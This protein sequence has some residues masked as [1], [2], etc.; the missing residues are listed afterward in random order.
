MLPIFIDRTACLL[1]VVASAGAHGRHFLPCHAAERTQRPP[2]PTSSPVDTTTSMADQWQS[3]D[4]ERPDSLPDEVEVTSR[5]VLRSWA[6]SK[7]IPL[8]HLTTLLKVMRRMTPEELY[9]LPL[10]VRTLLGGAGNLPPISSL[11]GG[12]YVHLGLVT[13][14]TDQLRA[15][16]MKMV[17]H[18]RLFNTH[19]LSGPSGPHQPRR[20]RR[21]SMRQ[22]IRWLM[23]SVAMLIGQVS[24]LRQQQAAR[25]NHGQEGMSS[26]PS[27]SARFNLSS[28]GTPEQLD[29][30]TSALGE[31]NYR[32][33]LVTYLCSLGGDTVE[34]FVD[35]VFG[36]LFSENITT[37]NLGRRH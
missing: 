8:Q 3:P 14:L 10:D 24:E 31:E 25:M 27:E 29:A 23:H 6:V 18:K 12:E 21:A 1:G 26:S 16:S 36:A 11:G 37:G 15:F 7:Q 19:R 20:R 22:G 33:Q 34:S 17:G 32:H 28:V 5:D 9:S 2:T 30:L 13:Q 4:E 35:R